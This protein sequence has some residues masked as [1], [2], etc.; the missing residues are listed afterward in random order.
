[1]TTF[2]LLMTRILIHTLLFF[3][4]LACS[5]GSNTTTDQGVDDGIIVPETTV[6]EIPGNQ[7]KYPQQPQSWQGVMANDSITLGA[8][9]LS[10]TPSQGRFGA[11]FKDQKTRDSL[12]AAYQNPYLK[13]LAVERYLED[14][15]DSLFTRLGDTLEIYT[16]DRNWQ[17]VNS[18]SQKYGLVDLLIAPDL[19]LIKTHY[20]SGQAYLL[21]NAGNGQLNYLWGRP[22]L[23]PDSSAIL[24]ARN[25]L[26]PPANR[27]ILETMCVKVHQLGVSAAATRSWAAQR[28]AFSGAG[29]HGRKSRR[30]RASSA[31]CCGREATSSW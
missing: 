29:C 18:D 7:Q 3:S 20:L 31:S 9:W 4:L 2:V 28:G 11:Y 21:F 16:P 5:C 13:C 30:R 12:A 19:F 27:R 10:F 17:I 25:L 6:V 26:H 24:V 14:E 8:Y 1:M 22:I 15:F 23:A